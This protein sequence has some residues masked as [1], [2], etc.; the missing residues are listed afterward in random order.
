M[1]V[2][3]I[4]IREKTVAEARVILERELNQAFCAGENMVSVLH[5]IGTGTL[6]TLTETYAADSGLARVMTRAPGSNP[7]ETQLEMLIPDQ[8]VLKKYLA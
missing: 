7:G 1:K 6:K 4:R 8:V 5:G 2:R 3:K